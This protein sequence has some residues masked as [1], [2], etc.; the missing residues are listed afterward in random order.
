MSD[1]KENR[2]LK[3]AF[4]FLTAI[5]CL[6]LID[7]FTKKLAVQ[8]L[9]DNGPFILIRNVLEFSYLENQGAAFGILQGKRTAFL[10]FA[11]AVSIGMFLYGLKLSKKKNM[12]PLVLCLIF[13]IAGALG[14]FID[15]LVNR[16]VVDFIYFSLI[17]FPVFNVADI[18]VTCGCILMM[19]LLLFKYKEAD[20]D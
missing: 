10:I 9:K 14:N 20:F 16:Y 15:R 6:I 7:Q 12:A 11:P 3:K 4:I 8:Y 19:L 5:F 1:N 2:I 13:V 18:Y 17:D